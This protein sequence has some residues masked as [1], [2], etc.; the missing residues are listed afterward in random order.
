MRTTITLDDDILHEAA[1]RA[2]ILKISLGKA[3]SDLA[4]RGMQATPP[5]KH[6]DGLVAFDPPQGSPKI[7]MP[8]VREALSDFP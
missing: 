2:R 6:A 7:T 8:K 4:R 1:K 3:V 5:V